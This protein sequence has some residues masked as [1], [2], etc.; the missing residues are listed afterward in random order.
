MMAATL[1]EGTT[2]LSNCAREPEVVDLAELL[3][4]MGASIRG[5]GTRRD[6]RSRGG[7]PLGGAEHT[8]IPDRIEA[9]HLP[10]RRRA[11]RRQGRGRR[12]P[13]RTTSSRCCEQLAAAGVEIEVE[14]DCLRVGAPE[15]LHAHDLRDRAAPGLSRPTC[16]RSTWR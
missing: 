10:G 7:T 14:G 8:V 1:A 13:R 16:R 4:A 3:T 6:R 5:A 11:D 9:G 12:L 2:V 15:R